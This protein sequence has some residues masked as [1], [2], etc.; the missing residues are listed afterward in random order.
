M[1]KE[2]HSLYKKSFIVHFITLTFCLLTSSI[3]NAQSGE[4]T[5]YIDSTQQIIRGFGAANIVTWRPD[6][7]TSEINTAFGMGDGQLGFSILRFRIPPQQNSFSINLPSAQAAYSKGVTLIA[8]PWSPPASM[9]TNNNTVGGELK[10]SSYADFAAYLNSFADYMSTN[11]AP[12]YAISVQN[13]PDVSV[14]Y[15]SCDY[16][17]SQ[18]LKFVQ[19]NGSSINTKVIAPESF[20]FNTSYSDLLLNDSSALENFDILGGHIY[21][22]GL[23]PIPSAEREGKEIWMTEHLDTDTTWAHV[24]ATGK[25]INDCMNAGMSAYVWWYIVRFYGPIDENGNVTKRGYI[26]SQYSKYIRPGFKKVWATQNPQS[27]VSLTAFTNGTKLVVVA[28]NESSASIAQTINLPNA[29]FTKFTPYVTSQTKNSNQEND[30]TISS[31]KTTATLDKSSVT[32]FVSDDVT[33]PVEI[34]SFNANVVENQINLTWSTASE[35]NNAGFEIERSIDLKNFVKIGYV[36]G[37]GTTSE[38]Q[39]YSFIDNLS[40]AK[41]YY[42]FKQIDFD[43]TFSYSKIVEVSTVHQTFSLLQNYPNPFNPVTQIKYS[44]P[45][46]T[47]ISLKVFNML[48]QEVATLF[49]GLQKTGNYTASFNGSGLASGLYIYQLKANDFVA[50]KKLLL[51]K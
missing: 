30:I 51:L 39:N 16:N 32:T 33:L 45:E 31:N 47:Y 28:V 34:I 26:M 5:I 41:I 12:I 1:K 50:T 10:E 4:A 49:E 43:G 44:V 21:G 20:H 35:S 23:Q 25:E 24:L 6:M 38:R 7:T 42:R 3:T 17:P 29:S 15:E 19:E 40:A 11:G 37:N 13:E 48:G 27:G 2:L 18:M 22:G 9:K 8:S 14:T 46:N 36:E